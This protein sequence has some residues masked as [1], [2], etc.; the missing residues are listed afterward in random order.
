MRTIALVDRAGVVVNTVAVEGEIPSFLTAWT[1]VDCPEIGGPS[2]GWTWDGKAFSPPA[3]PLQ[4]A[5]REYN[6]LH[7]GEEP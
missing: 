5:T 2:I 1:C 7:W 3:K 6:P 4:G